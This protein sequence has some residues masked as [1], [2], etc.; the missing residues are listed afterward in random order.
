MELVD[1]TEW[2]H[3]RLVCESPTQISELGCS[4]CNVYRLDYR[5][6]AHCP[7]RQL[8]ACTQQETLPKRSMILPERTS[9]TPFYKIVKIL[10]VKFE[11][12]GVD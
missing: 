7:W 10:G 12:D 6:L 2:S 1:A 5:L 9:Q 4:F 11:A 3:F 8:F